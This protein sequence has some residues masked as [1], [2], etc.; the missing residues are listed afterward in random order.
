MIMMKRYFPKL[1]KSEF[2][3]F[4]VGAHSTIAGFAFGIFVLFGVNGIDILVLYYNLLLVIIL[5]I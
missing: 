1:T 5:T 2:H 4:L 3:C